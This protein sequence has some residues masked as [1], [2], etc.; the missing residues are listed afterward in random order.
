MPVDPLSQGV[1][2]YFEVVREPMD[3]KTMDRKLKSHQ[4]SD[5]SQFDEDIRKIIA[6]SFAFNSPD[7]VYYSLTKDFQ[8]YYEVLRP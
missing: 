1:P 2:N 8:N 6:N 4:Y 5:E 3:L 7:T